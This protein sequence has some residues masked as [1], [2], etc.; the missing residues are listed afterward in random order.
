MNTKK[1]VWVGIEIARPLSLHESAGSLALGDINL[2]RHQV[3][4]ATKISSED[5]LCL[6][7]AQADEDA[8]EISSEF[9]CR[10]L[11]ALDFISMLADR[12]KGGE[13]GW[14]VNLRQTAPMK[15]AAVLVSALDTAGGKT[16]FSAS[17]PPVGHIRHQPLP[18][19]TEPDYRSLAFE[20]RPLSAFKV[21]LMLDTEEE[22]AWMDWG[23]F[24]EI[25]SPR[26]L[27]SAAEIV[28]TWK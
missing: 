25:T 13:Q 16:I 6:L 4:L 19:M 1:N 10:E 23:T 24:A 12:A 15:D 5:Q 3:M 27:E 20:I 28:S 7:T 26:D 2:L 9:G 14:V 8:L 22:L 21:D 11:G 17:K 18:G